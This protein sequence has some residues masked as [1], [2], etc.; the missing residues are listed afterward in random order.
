MVP[1]FLPL[2]LAQDHLVPKYT[3]FSILPGTLP[4]ATPWGR[5]PQWHVVLVSPGFSEPSPVNIQV[6]KS[7]KKW[8]SRISNEN[9]GRHDFSIDHEI[10]QANNGNN[11]TSRFSISS[12]QGMQRAWAN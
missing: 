5:L 2:L 11:Y 7:L 1:A 9:T 10:D 4:F 3:K 6:E 8:F 12:I